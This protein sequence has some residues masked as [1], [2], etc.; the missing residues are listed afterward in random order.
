M[1]DGVR[2]EAIMWAAR[3]SATSSCARRSSRS[4]SSARSA[5]RRRAS[6]RALR[7]GVTS[8]RMSTRPT[9][10]PEGSRTGDDECSIAL[11]S[12][13]SASSIAVR[14]GSPWIASIRSP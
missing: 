8:V 12:T 14:V 9:S 2:A 4:S 11:P 1:S 7:A 5:A 10:A 3:E 13:V 6:A